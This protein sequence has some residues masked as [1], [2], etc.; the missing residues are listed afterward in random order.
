M[1]LKRLWLCRTCKIVFFNQRQLEDLSLVTSLRVVS[2]GLTFSSH[3]G[4]QSFARTTIKCNA[5]TTLLP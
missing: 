5:G 3:F 1:L 2:D 4:S